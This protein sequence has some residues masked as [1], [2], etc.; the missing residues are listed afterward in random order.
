LRHRRH[1]DWDVWIEWYQDRLRGGSR[2]EA[3]ELVF[4]SV[5][6]EEWD[7]GPAAANAWIKRKI[8]LTEV[9]DPHA[10]I[11]FHDRR[12]FEK[13][14]EG[15]EPNVPVLLAT[16]AALRVLPVAIQI[17]DAKHG[18]ETRMAL[19]SMC[20]AFRAIALARV[21]AMWPR[22]APALQ[23]ALA[24]A[25][26]PAASHAMS[27]ARVAADGADAARL[28]VTRSAARASAARAAEK[29]T[30]ILANE[31]GPT[32]SPAAWEE[33]RFDARRVTLGAA[34]LSNCPIWSAGRDQ[35]WA[36]DAWARVRATLLGRK[37]G[38]SG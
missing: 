5:P 17:T 1:E 21:S 3:Y 33:T 2:G 11:D 15:Q 14:L 30:L 23:D 38:T 13:W 18:W 28:R 22:N 27:P 7:K 10:L 19:R 4:A 36:N 9:G 37:T 26:T 6:Q 35:M 20:E 16:R 29:A 8:R 12:S 34:G 32:A 24:S 25:V 31:A